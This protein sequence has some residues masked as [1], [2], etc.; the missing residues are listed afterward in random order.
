V[1]AGDKIYVCDRDGTVLV[2]KHSD[3]FEILGT[4]ELGEP[5]DATPAI[6]GD[7][8]FIKGA[9]HLYCIAQS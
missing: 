4:S 5:I 9:Q 8:L 2:L 1:A 3:T 6:V 7:E